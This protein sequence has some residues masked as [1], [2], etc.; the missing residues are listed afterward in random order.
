MSVGKILK[1]NGLKVF[2]VTVEWKLSGRLVK[3][4]QIWKESGECID[5]QVT[6]SLVW[7]L[8]KCLGRDQW[9]TLD[10]NLQHILGPLTF[11][12]THWPY[13][14]TGIRHSVS[15]S[16]EPEPCEK[17][18][19]RIFFQRTKGRVYL[20]IITVWTVSLLICS[21]PLMGEKPTMILYLFLFQAGMT[22]QMSLPQTHHACWQRRRV[23]LNCICHRRHNGT[24]K[25]WEGYNVQS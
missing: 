7:W 10:I 9:E 17:W 19:N 22:G 25:Y 12:P 18:W 23:I 13:S 3:T 21:P 2:P 15:N 1:Q 14:P 6:P 16:I 24:E 20:M 5:L 11:N 4:N 8:I